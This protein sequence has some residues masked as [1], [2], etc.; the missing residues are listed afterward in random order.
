[1]LGR[2]AASAGCDKKIT[3]AQGIKNLKLQFMTEYC[4]NWSLAD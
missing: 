1:M 3:S 2:L 4:I